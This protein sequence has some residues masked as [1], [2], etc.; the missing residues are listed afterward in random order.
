MPVGAQIKP[1]LAFLETHYILNVVS[2]QMVNRRFLKIFV[3]LDGYYQTNY[4]KIKMTC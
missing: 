1:L 3:T 2:L 4:K